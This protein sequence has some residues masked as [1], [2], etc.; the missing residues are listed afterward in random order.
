ML[1]ISES[2]GNNLVV[3][4]KYIV[5]GKIWL[6]EKQGR[7]CV[8][9]YQKHKN[10]LLRTGGAAGH[11]ADENGIARC[12]NTA[13]FL[14]PAASCAETISSAFVCPYFKLLPFLR[15]PLYSDHLFF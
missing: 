11:R 13:V 1:R 7:R 2:E 8:C 6:A 9:F 10:L 12:N 3:L 5:N 4:Y 15:V 14:L